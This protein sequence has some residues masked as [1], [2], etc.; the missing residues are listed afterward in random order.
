MAGAFGFE[1]G[2]HYQVSVACGERALL[3]EVRQASDDT[4]I[5]A[6][7]FS[8]REQIRQSTDRHPLHLA[9]V[10]QLALHP[11]PSEDR[12]EKPIVARRRS[13]FRLAAA[14]TAALVATGA[15]IG[16]WLYKR[17]ARQ[18]AVL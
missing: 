4:I 18:H 13:H 17:R 1:E 2:D 16:G 7:G 14:Q 8:C 9:Q 6:D 12:P 3:P 11:Q 15:M 5:C 10:M